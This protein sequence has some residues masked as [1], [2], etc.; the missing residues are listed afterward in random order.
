M[1]NGTTRL[2]T[3]VAIICL[4]PAVTRSTVHAQTT[5]PGGQ[6]DLIMTNGQI[7][8]PS[9]W[10]EA[11]AIRGGIIVAVGE[12]ETIGAMSGPETEILDLGGDTVLPG[13]HDL[14]V[15]PL[16]AGMEQFACGLEPG[17]S[18]RAIAGAVKACVAAKQ[19]GEWIQGGNWVAAVFEPGQQ[20]R[21]FLDA[22]APDNPVFLFDESHHSVWANSMALKLAGITRDTPDPEGGIIE[23]DSAG[24]PNGLL[25]E[26]A[27]DLVFSVIPPALEDTKRKALILAANQM[28]SNGITSFTDAYV[29]PWHIGAMS[30]L[31]REGLLKQRVRG[32]IHWEPGPKAANGLSEALIAARSTYAGPRF[33]LDCV[34]IVLDGVPTESHTAAMLE[35]YEDS[36]AVQGDERREKGLLLIP[37]EVLDKAVTRFDRQGLR[38]KFHAAGDAAVRAAIDAVAKAREING[39]GGPTHDVGHN[40]FVHPADIPRVRDLQMSWEFSPFIW[41][42]TPIAAV[43][44]RA[45]VGDERMKRWIPIK[46]AVDTGAL[47]VAGSDWPVVPIVNP[48]LGMETMVTRQQPGGSDTTLGEQER[49]TLDE[50]FRIFT[51]NGATLMGQR[52][53]VG[54]I[55]VGMHADLIVTET[56]PFKVPIAQLH[57]T[58]VRMT[59]IDG[60]KEFDAASP[61]KL[62][63][64]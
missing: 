37:Q 29:T 50:A 64:H 22:V 62:A 63:A 47:V 45:A 59:F 11:V 60:E 3:A 16:M 8:T 23:R 6:V 26:N 21:A 51:E 28:L 33:S 53:K 39:H 57:A 41:Y 31:S 46:D 2:A 12:A 40:S 9:G 27:T 15:H 20:D 49:V 14:H 35:A 61:P 43:D 36:K 58:K 44:I 19:R 1:R 34:K 42:P 13:L 48:W 32:C 10:A 17:A 52:D 30:A 24:E 55:E 54:S 4:A 38:I 56:N 5:A 18:A 7:K 25:R